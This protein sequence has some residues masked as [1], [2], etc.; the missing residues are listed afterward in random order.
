MYMVKKNSFNCYCGY[1][2]VPITHLFYKAEPGRFDLRVH[3]GATF[4]GTFE[5]IGDGFYFFGFDC[6]HYQDFMPGMTKFTGIGLVSQEETYKDF[7]FVLGQIWGLIEQL[8]S[9][10]ECFTQSLRSGS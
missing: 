8:E 2:G 4:T 9:P 3:G 6:A 1:V 7:D 5:E 10:L